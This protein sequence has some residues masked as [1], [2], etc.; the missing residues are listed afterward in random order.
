MKKFVFLAVVL[1]F[2]RQ[3]CA[4]ERNQDIQSLVVHGD[5]Y[6]SACSQASKIHLYTEIAVKKHKK[7]PDDLWRLMNAMLC[8]KGEK[9]E[10]FVL[11]RM[12]G[13]ITEVN[14]EAEYGMYRERLSTREEKLSLMAGS[15]AWNPELEFLAAGPV[16]VRLSYWINEVCVNDLEFAYKNGLWHIVGAGILCDETHLL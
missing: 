9:D 4:S 2:V 7:A 12:P 3:A 11:S 6:T 14:R 10:H 15:A 16:E 1:L 5:L 8:G 13:D